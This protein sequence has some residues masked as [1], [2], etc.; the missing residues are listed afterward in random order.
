MKNK[1]KYGKYHQSLIRSDYEIGTPFFTIHS[2][3]MNTF[4]HDNYAIFISGSYMTALI[5]DLDSSFYLFD[6]HARNS[7]G[8]LMLMVQL[9]P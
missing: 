5:R 8:C 4:T 1:G 3:L 2:A 7:N 9:L 6:A